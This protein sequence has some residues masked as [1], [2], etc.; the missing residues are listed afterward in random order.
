MQTDPKI[1]VD[2][3]K[4][5]IIAQ[6]IV[7]EIKESRAGNEKRYTLAARCERQYAQITTYMEAGKLCDNPWKGAAD[8]FI[9]LTEWIIDAVHARVMQTLFSQEPYMTAEATAAE[10]VQN[11]PN[12][13]DF[14]DM[15]FREIVNLRDNYSYF[16][17][18][19]LK[20]PF[21]VMKY[22]WCQEFEPMIVKEQAL[23]FINQATGDTQYLL[24]DDPDNTIKAAQFM[25]QGY[26]QSEQQEV[27]VK[28][29][30]ELVNSPQ[31][32]YIKFEDYV[33]SL[34]AKRGTRLYWEGDR[35][36]F[37][38]GEMRNY[39]SQEKF[40]EESV[41]RIEREIL[42]EGKTETERAISE[43]AALRECYNWYGRLP[44]DKS[45]EIAFNDSE[46][47][48]QEVICIV[49]FK[50]EE[51]LMIK[52]WDNAR[53]PYPERV[54]IRGEFE[55]TEEFE[56]RSLAM[57]LYQTQKL[58]NQFYNTT[59]NNAWIAMQKIFVKRRTL[60]GED[61]EKPE[62][63]PGAMWE[64]D[65]Q[66]DIRALEVGDVKSIGMEIENSLL[67]F[68]ARI[69]NI[70]IYQTGASRQQGQKT[71]GEVIATI[72]EGNIGMD[73]F[74]QKCHEDLR[75]L[76]EWTISYYSDRMPPDMQRMLKGEAGEKIFPSSQNM[77]LFQKKGIQPY[78]TEDNLTGKF[79]WKWLGTSLNSSKEL[80]IAIANDLQERFLPVPMVAGNLLAVKDILRRGLV[81]RNI[82]DWQKLLPSDEDLVNEMKRMQAEAQARKVRMQQGNMKQA[83]T[84]KLIDKGLPP[85]QAQAAVERKMGAVQ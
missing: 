47:I 21:T 80:N 22:E 61:W 34:T 58:I 52:H 65:N 41:K 68:A 8:Y 33:Y 53:I 48:E 28:Q 2:N 24:P 9:A 62:V 17:K 38:I 67:S 12:A 56:G 78:W 1:E 55:E 4:E 32:K 84:N 49:D 31:L 14:V 3:A 79:N 70:D 6:I 75:K 29:D 5:K 10:Y 45:N 46:A 81:A 72:Q 15:V 85:E 54:Y 73:K 57:K 69:S 64:E 50:A 59:L 23:T 35:C 51:L 74:I 26:Q 42:G 25:L 30:K 76:C 83:V 63:C 11:A 18:Q 39:V 43:R 20:L 16:C 71:K 19:K 13:T 36:W 66:G 44:F 82:K 60:Q 77:E 37:T 7:K 27:W 40:I